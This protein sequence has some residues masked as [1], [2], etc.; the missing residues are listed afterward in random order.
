LPDWHKSLY[1]LS[2]AIEGNW[3]RERHISCCSRKEAKGMAWWRTEGCRF[4]GV[5]G[6][7]HEVKRMMTHFVMLRCVETPNCRVEAISQ[8][9]RSSHKQFF[10]R[11]LETVVI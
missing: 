8:K 1:V 10:L 5:G 6:D 4:K 7:P 9:W 3:G 11:K 2:S